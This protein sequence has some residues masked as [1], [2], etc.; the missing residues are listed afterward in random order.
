MRQL[1]IAER[2]TAAAVVPA[3]VL[4]GGIFF[5]GSHAAVAAAWMAAIPL[6]A[7]LAV[8][9]AGRAISRRVRQAAE[10]IDAIAYAEL[11]SAA[12]RIPA[13][14]EVADLLAATGR[15][16]EILNERQR[17]HL[18][19]DD[20]DRAWQTL[21]R[22]NLSNLAPQVETAT[23]AGIRPI[24]QGA[25]ALQDGAAEML[26]AL[27]NVQAAFEQ[28]M[29]A[30]E[31]SRAMDEAATQL[32][33]RVLGAIAEI[34]EQV[35]RG[36]ASAQE[37]VS[38]AQ[39]ARGA[40][41]VLSKA[42]G[43]I[44]DIV[45]V[46]SRIAAQTN[47]LALNATI[48]A[49]RAGEAG[50]G[51]SVVASEV[52]TLAM[53]TGRSTG[54]IG[55]KVAEIQS[56][57]RDVVAALASV[58]DAV[59]QVSGVTQSVPLA[60]ERQRSATADFASQ[61]HDSM[62]VLCEVAERIVK[63]GETVKLSRERAQNVS[64]IAAGMQAASRALC[65][66][67]PEIVRAAVKA[68]LREFPRYEVSLTARLS[69]RGRTADVDVMDV[70][71]GGARIGAAEELAVGDKVALTLPGTRTIAG[72]VVR[73]AEDGF[74]VCFTPARLRLEELRDLVTAPRAA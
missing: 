27:A 25:T 31:G 36:S 6:A 11:A 58:A 7:G 39:H 30:A 54:Q 50:R 67:I 42:A 29:R 2:L 3:A 62:A 51:F 55:A 17:R 22:A 28:T 33:H 56:A 8:F 44:G 26:A 23:E 12:P 48:E 16:A 72:E 9:V 43:Q 18:V 65:G 19:H 52:K 46:I 13:R 71:E 14:N 5:F 37:A 32:S 38:R 41:E 57:T 49:A 40:I 4:I 60:I 24:A 63:I 66:E 1:T 21:R 47:L 73:M 68:D 34:A 61:A 10:A 45:T 15:L 70:S 35:Q 53:Q 20:L 74:G 59:D 64:T 69:Y